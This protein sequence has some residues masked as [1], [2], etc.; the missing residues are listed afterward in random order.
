MASITTATYTY[1]EKNT[2]YPDYHTFPLH[3]THNNLAQCLKNSNLENF[4]FQESESEKKNQLTFT[5][6]I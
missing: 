4:Q 3:K 2:Q 6:T 5:S 1:P